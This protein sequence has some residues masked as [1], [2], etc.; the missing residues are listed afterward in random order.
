MESEFIDYEDQ[1]V[2]LEGYF[3]TPDKEKKRPL[4]L[5]SHDWTGRRQYAINKAN[6]MAALGYAAF[7]VDMYGKGVF[8]KDGDADFNSQLMAPFAGDRALLRARIGSALSAAK[9]LS[10]VDPKRVGAIGYCFGGMCVLELARGG[11][12]VR[13]VISVHGIFSPGA[14]P[15]E[16]VS[17]KILCLHGTMIRWCHRTGT[18]LRRDERVEQTGRCM[19][20][21]ERHTPSLILMRTIQISARYTQSE[22]TTGRIDLW[23]ISSRK[24]LMVERYFS[25]VG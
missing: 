19:S 13:G 23:L 5:V 4:I 12:D 9:S 17:S 11:S 10:G 1:G 25:S 6:E 20:T 24:Y 14:V 16:S 3:V 8:G 21:E 15:N 22:P 2:A 18:T 7:A